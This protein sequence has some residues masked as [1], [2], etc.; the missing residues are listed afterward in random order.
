MGFR[1]ASLYWTMKYTFSSVYIERIVTAVVS[2]GR[3]FLPRTVRG[4]A[5]FQ[6][7]FIIPSRVGPAA[8]C[9]ETR[10]FFGCAAVRPSSHHELP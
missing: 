2:P 1:V 8:T 10:R 6:A 4:A 9:F 3:F 5:S 7:S